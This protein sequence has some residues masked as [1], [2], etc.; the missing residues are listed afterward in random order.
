MRIT[1][2][3]F[4]SRALASPR[5]HATRPTSDRVRE[6]LFSMLASAGAFDEG[7]PRVLD[8]YAGSGA[9]GLEALSRGARAVTLVE[10]ARAAISAIRQNVEA[11]GVRGAVTII[12]LRVDRALAD[13]EGPF[14]L[15]LIDPPYEEVRARGFAGVLDR[16]ARL[17][18]PRG[19]LVLEHGSSDDPGPPEGLAL[20]RRRRYGDTTLS[21]FR[22]ASERDP[23]GGDEAASADHS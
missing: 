18:G 15:V 7:A 17:L 9:L 11:L 22:A 12:P 20:D 16:A 6:A 23:T 1:G 8:L 10:S 19:I 21:L 3:V 5:G 4:R 13:L 2:G 14:E